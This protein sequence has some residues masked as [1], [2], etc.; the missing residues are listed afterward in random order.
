MGANSSILI[1]IGAKAADAISEFNKLD[2]AIG[3]HLT[4]TQKVQAAVQRAA[5]PAGIALA[6][7]GA[8]AVVATKAAA[9]DAAAQEKLAGQLQRVAG[10][11][12][13]AVAG[14]EAFISAL[15]Q[16]VGV[17][18]DEL[19]PALGKLATATGDVQKA[20]DLLKLSLDISAQTG[21]PLEAVTTSLGKAY[22][23]NLGALKKLIPGFDEGIIKS[24]DFTKAQ[25][26]LARLTGG[27]AQESANTASG[28]FRRLGITLQETQEAIGGALLPI[29]NALLPVLQSVA[30]WVQ[31]NTDVVVAASAAFA[32]IA[33]TIV[34]TNAVMKVWTTVT[35]IARAAVVAFTAVQ[36]LFNAAVSANPIGLII[37]AV[38]A[39]AAGMVLL[40]EKFEPVRN[41][42][43][44]LF[45]AL[46]PVGQWILTAFTVYWNS[47]VLIFQAYKT[48]VEEVIAA[49]GGIV[50]GFTAAW[51]WLKSTFTPVWNVLKTAID[52]VSTVISDVIS[53]VGSIKSGLE[54]FGS[55]V[56][57]SAKA[58]WE[59][60]AG[61]VNLVLTPILTLKSAVEWLIRHLPDI[62]GTGGNPLGS[63]TPR[64]G[65]GYFGPSVKSS[66]AVTVNVSPSAQME[67]DDEALAR[68]ISRLLFGSEVRNGLVVNYA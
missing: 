38:A 6:A 62:E 7:M 64:K 24:K 49:V 43:D 18:D 21:R 17:A 36:W 65:G 3:D 26:E 41:A 30:T 56:A 54:S 23:G 20:Q 8:A 40:Y 15:S 37:I 61:F 12:T 53:G 28:Q 55:W 5:V 4:K 32:G 29:L 27:A 45:E 35:Q 44:A 52:A 66:N 34:T 60:L 1:T 46:K 47:L 13:A 39:F 22:G 19:R 50:N 25:A 11:N 9:E 67:V 48:V 63:K 51:S 42:V 68:A 33:A 58:A 16:Q 59:K 31:N 10:A 2:R 57:S 14:A